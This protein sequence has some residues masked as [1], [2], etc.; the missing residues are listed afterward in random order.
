MALV[1]PVN[2]ADLTAAAYGR[3]KPQVP[4]RERAVWLAGRLVSDALCRPA[5]ACAAVLEQRDPPPGWRGGALAS[6]RSLA[7]GAARGGRALAVH[8][9]QE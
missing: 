4:A 8:P 1:M 6:L 3:R 9:S 5:E 2:A 7:P